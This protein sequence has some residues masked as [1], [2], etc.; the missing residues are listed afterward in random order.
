MSASANKKEQPNDRQPNLAY[1]LL[2]DFFKHWQV[3]VLICG[4]LFSAYQVVNYAWEN[5]Q[6]NAKLQM[7]LEEK[8]KLDIDFRHMLIEHNALSE[9]N[10][11]EQKAKEKL[12]MKRPQGDEEKI[13]RTQ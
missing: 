13:I 3:P 7:L 1:L 12:N 5:R 2:V 10:R 4:I 11:I 6:L 8:D 9:H